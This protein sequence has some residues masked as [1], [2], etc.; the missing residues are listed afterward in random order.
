MTE[1][2]NDYE[3]CCLA[4]M[5]EC[6]SSGI[7][8]ID[9]VTEMLKIDK[10]FQ[11]ERSRTQ[12]RSG[13]RSRTRRTRRIGS[14]A[15]YH[16][17]Q[18]NV[19]NF[20][21]LEKPEIHTET[22]PNPKIEV[23][24]LNKETIYKTILNSLQQ[25]VGKYELTFYGRIVFDYF[26]QQQDKKVMPN[27]IDILSESVDVCL[28]LLLLTFQ[29]SF[30]IESK[31]SGNSFIHVTMAYKLI[32]SVSIIINIANVS[33]IT[34]ISKNIDIYSIGMKVKLGQNNFM[35]EYLVGIKEEIP[36]VNLI[37][38]CCNIKEKRFTI[39]NKITLKQEEIRTIPIAPF[40]FLEDTTTAFPEYDTLLREYKDEYKDEYVG[41]GA[42]RIEQKT[43]E[44]GEFNKF[45]IYL[46]QFL[47]IIGLLNN[48]WEINTEKSIKFE[49]NSDN[50]DNNDDNNDICVIHKL[51]SNFEC[52][53]C[54][55]INKNNSYVLKLTCCNQL[56]CS[57]CLIIYFCNGSKLCAF[58]QSS[59]PKTKN[60]TK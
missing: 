54:Y 29:L 12:S 43:N 53:I 16:E 50:G 52:P 30:N 60:K 55:N 31:M 20:I 51:N 9:E 22:T 58:C 3:R 33:V 23:I 19:N 39:I 28:K 18:L 46:H 25:F 26:A 24:E 49:G 6:Y 35:S 34:E 36:L 48:G 57:D 45:S 5:D 11:N 13:S 2:K 14:S 10:Y 59:V 7:A 42:Y 38:L 21:N 4:E 37:N 40:S 1:R 44:N 41:R 8:E 56:V 17:Y 27:T 47:I 15:N 32:P